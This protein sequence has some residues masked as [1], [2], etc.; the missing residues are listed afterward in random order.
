MALDILKPQI[1]R[2]TKSTNNLIITTYGL[3]GLGKTP[4]ATKMEKPCYLAFG[5]SGLD[6]LNNVPFFSIKTWSEFKSFNKALCNKKDYDAI[7][8]MYQTIILDEMEILWSYCEQYVCQI[9]S[10]TK[11]KEGN[12]GYGLW[13]DLRTEWETEILRLIGSGF[14]VMFILHA[15]P[16]DNGRMFPVGDVKR[17]LPIILNHSAIIG[18]VKGNGVNPET[19][20][21]IH[22]SLM[23]AGTEDYFARTR[24]EYFDPV[25]DDYTAEN[26]IKAYYDALDK[27][28]KEEG[29]KP[30]TLEEK[31]EMYAVEEID[32]D[33]LMDEIQEYGGKLAEAKGVEILTDIVE[34]VLGAGKKA[35]DLTKKQ[36]QAAQVILA[37]IKSAL[38]E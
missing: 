5:K 15:A 30:I 27:Q 22:S 21:S 36:T 34:N 38:N 37:D 6:G 17:M 1:S 23:L 12:S 25:I 24:N 7:H 10:V 32:F 14:C 4:V 3:G 16:D 28:E 11:I 31:E 13:G 29:V 2:V 26:L 33:A 20:R 35:M 18:Y 9:N 8:E 19:G